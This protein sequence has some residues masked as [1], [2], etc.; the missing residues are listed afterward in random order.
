M[1]INNPTYRLKLYGFK[2]IKKY[3][4]FLINITLQNIKIQKNVI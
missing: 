1:G 4:Y 3:M 2:H